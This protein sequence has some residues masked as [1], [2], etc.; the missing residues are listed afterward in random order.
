MNKIVNFLCNNCNQSLE[1]DVDMIGSVINCPSC[2]E[3]IT[4][5]CLIEEKPAVI[6]R[7]INHIPYGFGISR[8][9]PFGKKINNEMP[10][11]PHRNS[12]KNVKTG[13]WITMSVLSAIIVF[14]FYIAFSNYSPKIYKTLNISV[15]TS[16]YAITIQ[17]INSP[18]DAGKNIDVYINGM[19]PF[20]FKANCTLPTVG[21][22]VSI[23]VNEF[24]K[25]DGSRFNPFAYAVTEIWV[26]GA[27]Y[28]Y[29]KYGN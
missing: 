7:V 2:N 22:K 24:I 18:N 1:A 10:S 23:N 17:N 3:P 11:T 13:K 9:E 26:G 14:F 4:I 6:P 20:S 21:D 5:P 19:P 15:F 8:D 29:C 16:R 28:D 12:S 27:G 25:K